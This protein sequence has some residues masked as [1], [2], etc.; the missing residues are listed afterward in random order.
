MPLV[1][2]LLGQRQIICLPPSHFEEVLY[3]WAFSVPPTRWAAAKQICAPV[4]DAFF[5]RDFAAEIYSDQVLD[6]K[7]MS[8]H[9]FKRYKKKTQPPLSSQKSGQVSQPCSTSSGLMERKRNGPYITRTPCILKTTLSNSLLTITKQT[10]KKN[11]DAYLLCSSSIQ[12]LITRNTVLSK[13]QGM[14]KKKKFQCQVAICILGK[15]NTHS[16]QC[17]LETPEK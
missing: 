5:H 9:L 12:L 4:N 11:I 14:K 3:K 7:Q 2:Q 8:E 17:F 16:F 1:V 10:G 15:T 13:L 6:I